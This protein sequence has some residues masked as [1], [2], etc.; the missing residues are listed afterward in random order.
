MAKKLSFSPKVDQVFRTD[1]SGERPFEFNAEVADAF[2]DMAARSIPG[3]RQ[4][5]RTAVWL[6]VEHV[7][8]MFSHGKVY[9]L[10]A[11]TGALEAALLEQ[12]QTQG[13]RFVAVDSSQEMAERAKA[14]LQNHPRAHTVQW[15]VEDIQETPI[16]D[17]ILVVSHYC[18]QFVPPDA[19]TDILE[20]IYE[21]LRPGG[22]FLLSEKT[23]EDAHQEQ[24]F[25]SRYE[26]FKRDEGYSQAE[27]DNKK[28]AL[29]GV[30]IPWSA[31]QNEAALRLAGFE[32]PVRLM[33][34]WN[35]S[36]WVARKPAE[37]AS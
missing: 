29:D 14:R 17:A 25:R 30:L 27:I 1:E 24:Y 21:G 13:W 23:E 2:D 32:E 33:K 26:A 3:Y 12:P 16:E 11:S 5:L 20:R 7:A 31:A 34:H 35:F 36:T 15:R 22:F 8:P 19:R 10:G 18:L 37:D 6:A 4:S 9:D 28:K